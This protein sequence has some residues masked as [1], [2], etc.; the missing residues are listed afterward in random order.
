MTVRD[1]V[2][3]LQE[4]LSAAL[5]QLQF[6]QQ[7]TPIYYES[8]DVYIKRAEIALAKAEEAIHRI[9]TAPKVIIDRRKAEKEDK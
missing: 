8:L 9:D 2:S 6:M 4:E 3:L 5:G 1:V 7:I